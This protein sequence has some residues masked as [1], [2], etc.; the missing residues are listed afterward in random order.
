VAAALYEYGV[1]RKNNGVMPCALCEALFLRG[2]KHTK[3]C[4]RCGLLRRREY[5]R[6]RKNLEYHLRRELVAVFESM[7][8]E[9]PEWQKKNEKKMIEKNLL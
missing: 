9:V 1:E 3:F 8:V 5:D 4:K 6:L 7:D 2:A